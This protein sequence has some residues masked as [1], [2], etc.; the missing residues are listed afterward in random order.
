MIDDRTQELQNRMSESQMRLAFAIA[1]AER[2]TLRREAHHAF[3]LACIPTL[4]APPERSGSV[5]TAETYLEWAEELHKMA[6]TLLAYKEKYPCKPLPE[7]NISGS[8]LQTVSD[9][10]NKPGPTDLPG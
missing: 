3:V 2:E 7:F 4:K 9:S 6:D 10:T 1:K 5:A 8:T